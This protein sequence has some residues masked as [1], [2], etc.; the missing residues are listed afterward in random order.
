MKY[1]DYYQILGVERDAS[2]EAIKKAYRKLAR[3]YHPDVSKEPNAEERFKEINEANDVL[4]DAE[5]RAAYDRLGRHRPGEDFRPPP[6]WAEQ[7]AHG[8]GAGGAGGFTEE[9][10]LS[11]LFADL[12]GGAT[13]ARR[14]ARGGFAM[15]G[16]DYE[17]VVHL[18]LEEA[19]R[20]TEVSLN[21]EMPEAGP[22]RVPR[23]VPKTV[24]VRIPKG[25]IDG[26]KLRVPG[27]GGPG[28]G[29]GAPGALYLD[30]T[31]R[32]HAL[33]KPSGHDLYLEVPIAPWEATLGAQIEVPT[34]DGKVRIK[35][36]PGARAGQKL[37]LSGKGMPKPGG[38]HGDLYAVL[39]IVT[40]T[41]L[42]EEEK[43]HFEEL[44]RISRFN[45]RGHFEV[46]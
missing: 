5:K 41:I 9:V 36:G 38:G 19:A 18:T 31:L 46:S 3:K 29:G 23:R 44:A 10:D 32:P 21:L 30:I 33:F 25:V 26:Q 16:Q 45:P 43:R 13:R 7:F 35:V 1:K 17:V 24:K 12:F 28:I 6:D 22:D 14:G 4:S 42:S 34:L 27:K 15:P 2:E 20:G 39:S 8:F 37:R 40:P 11:D